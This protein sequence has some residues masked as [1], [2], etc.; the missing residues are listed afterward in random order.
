MAAAIIT[1]ASEDFDSRTSSVIIALPAPIDISSASSSSPA[2]RHAAAGSRRKRARNSG[3]ASSRSISRA[4]TSASALATS[5]SPE[6]LP[7]RLAEHQDHRKEERDP[8]G[9]HDGVDDGLRR[10]FQEDL[11]VTERERD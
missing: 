9:P 4:A 3:S 8:Q 11:L 2:S 5:A 1:P 7:Q 6:P 10:Q